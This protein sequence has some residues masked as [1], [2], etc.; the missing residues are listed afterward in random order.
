MATSS[1]ARYVSVLAN[2]LNSSGKITSDNVLLPDSGVTA[3]SYGSASQ[4]PVLT[5]DSK[6]RVTSASV[7]SVA[8]VTAYSYNTSSGRMTINTADGGSFTADVTL[9]P[10]STTNLTEGTNQYFTTA[11]ARS[12]I[13]STGTNLSYNSTTGVLSY[14][15]GNTDTVA[16]GAT[17]LYYTDARARDALSYT[18]GNASYNS[19][20]GQFT[21]PSTT[22]HI[23][24]GSNLYYTDARVRAA[25]S[26]GT[27]VTYNSATGSFSIGQPVATT[28]NVNFATVTTSGDVVVGGNLTVSGTTTTVNSTTV[29]VADINI[30]VARNATTAAQANG[31][32]L[33][34]TGPTVPATLTYSSA[35]DRWNLNKDLNINRVY[36][37]ITGAVTGNASTASTLETTR[38]ITATGDAS[39]TVNFN[40]AA[41]VSGALTLANSG[42]TAGSYGSGT[43]IPVLT[44]DSKGRITSA[45]TSAVTIGDGAMTVTAGSGLTGGGQLGTANQTGASNITISH[46]DTSSVSNLSSDNSG[47][48]VIQDISLTFDTYGHVTGASVSTANINTVDHTYYGII[49]DTRA[50][51]YT[52]N[53]YTDYR[54]TWEFT[55]Q[56]PIQGGDWMS[57][58]TLQGWHNGY[59]AWQIIGP[60][61]TGAHENW[62]LRSG[63]NTSWNTARKIWHDGNLTNL[64]QLTNGPGYITGESDT[65]ATVTARGATTSTAIT[66]NNTITSSSTIQANNGRIVLRDDSIE[67]WASASDSA[68]IAVN[69]YGYSSGT[70]YYRDFVV[71]D[72]KSGL[73][74]KTYG[75][76]NYSYAS[77]SMRASIFYDN[78]DTSYYGDFAST[79]WMNAVKANV[80]C[81]RD[82]NGYGLYKGYD[83]NN[84]FISIRGAVSGTNSSLTITGAH[85]TTFVEHMSP[86]DSTTGWFFKDSYS[87]GNF[88]Y[89]TIA[90]ISASDSWVMNYL[91]GENSLRAPIF[92]DSNDTSYYVDPN[93]QSRIHNLIIQGDWGNYAAPWNGQLTIRG[94]YPSVQFRSSTS[95][96]VWLRHMDVAGEIQHYYASDGIDSNNWS[97]KHTMYRDGTFYSAASMRSPIFYDAND[98]AYRTDPNDWTVFNYLRVAQGSYTGLL[99]GN[100][101]TARLHDDG[102]TRAGISITGYAYPHIDINATSSSN[103]TH[104]SV[105]SFTGEISGGYRRWGMGVANWNPNELSFGWFDNQANPH[106]GV[107][108][109]WQYPASM[110]IDTGHNLYARGS[111]RAPIFYDYND[112]AWYTDPASTSRMRNIDVCSGTY[113]STY[114]DAAI[115]VREYNMEGAGD[116]TWQRAPRIGFHWGGRVASSIAMSSNGWI[117]IMNNPG[118]G[119]EAFRASD[120]YATGVVTAG[121][122]DERLKTKVGKIQNA[123][124][125]VKAIETFKYIHNDIAKENGFSGDDVQVGVSAQS[126]EKVLPEIVKHAPFDMQS[127]DGNIVSKS[128]EWYKTV[129]Y[130]KLT[131]LLIEAIKEQDDKIT[132][133]GALVETLINKLGEK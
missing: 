46:A 43:A 107:G 72:G 75:S 47:N 85:Q 7:T 129:D 91:T 68:G 110:W 121:Y 74:F 19:I 112:T 133:L 84:H 63:V 119:F 58:M 67:N 15:Q 97:I 128:G 8:G 57:A 2:T 94:G 11:R 77:G 39:W 36:G 70:S 55:N 32:G 42:V 60:A 28:D 51:Q 41:N 130:E 90:R 117:N 78:D 120:I 69:Y 21:I 114:Y 89:A 106:Y 3:G 65:L 101:S 93:G 45:S 24:E 25:I 27:G 105:L 109:S 113:S 131:P 115:E 17:N 13:S 87:G 125:S 56:I 14:T 52:P 76:G 86:A 9:A 16:E 35:D 81:G 66:I 48:T 71:Y 62:Y 96:S 29:S 64:N 23:S 50:A 4:V 88:N 26:G 127:L 40:G 103:P 49:Q 31:A 54:T 6:G 5:V 33:T 98:T 37:N 53:D 116:D 20:S 123:L 82:S 111:M 124:E 83:N 118:T 79:S 30:E 44:I 18:T 95:N 126:V 59:S 92:Y 73:R 10:F 1:R 122:S 80:F 104:G 102:S 34:V 38:S 12:S 99:I 108:I 22:A 61:S 100:G 132:R